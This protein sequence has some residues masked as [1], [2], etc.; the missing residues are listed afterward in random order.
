MVLSTF[1]AFRPAA[2]MFAML[3]ILPDGAFAD[4][5]LLGEAQVIRA[6]M[7]ASPDVQAILKEEAEGIAD[8]DQAGL[9]DNPTVDV[10]V[11]R[12][13]SRGGDSNRYD[14]EIEQPLKFSQMTG[15][16]LRLSRALYEQAEIR[17]QHGMLRAYWE[18]KILYAQAWQY[19]EQE[20]L[21]VNFMKRAQDAAAQMNRSVK[22]GQKAVSEG[23]LFAGDAAKFG[24]D[25]EKI[26]AQKSELFL[27]LEK[28]TALS[29]VGVELERP[30]FG[31]I[32]RDPVAL[33]EAARKNAS[34]V[35]LLEADLQAAER[36]KQAAIAD[37]ALPEI[38]PRFIYGRSPD[39]KEDTVGV[40]VVLTIPLW[41][42]HQSERRKAEAAGIYARRQLDMLQAV[43]L[44]DRLG[45]VIDAIEML[46]RRIG[47]LEGEALPNYRKGFSQAQK[48][49]RAGQTDAIALWQIRERLFQT[50]RE[51]LEATLDAIEARRA[52]SIETGT[53]PQEAML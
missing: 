26:R 13:S 18:S 45:R 2:L 46:E 42:R 43:P 3:V 23:S 9:F 53:M 1:R 35:R 29:L 30:V 27:K 40:G 34:L 39:D 38:A 14:L 32:S 49:F 50:E 5:Q 24:S 28:S 33:A 17:A 20:K 21:H 36:Q 31:E 7:G 41:D 22:A 10:A 48:S 11:T 37:S 8:A 52:L 15:S 4:T 25:L 6:A 19:Q 16:R 47:I 12:T 44:S 51:L